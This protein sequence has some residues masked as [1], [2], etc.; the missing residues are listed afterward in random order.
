MATWMVSIDKTDV[1]TA[2]GNMRHANP[3]LMLIKYAQ[4]VTDEMHDVQVR[5]FA[6]CGLGVGQNLL[7][8]NSVGCNPMTLKGLMVSAAGLEPA[9]HALKGHCST[10]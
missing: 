7:A 4:A 9:T 2:Q 8:E 6:S 10:N 5:W 3:E 1:K